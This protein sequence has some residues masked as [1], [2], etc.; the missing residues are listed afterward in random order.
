VNGSQW[1]AFVTCFVDSGRPSAADDICSIELPLPY[2]GINTLQF[3]VFEEGAFAAAHPLHTLV[4]WL[5]LQG[6]YGVA[7]STAPRR[8]C[9]MK[10]AAAYLW[11]D[12]PYPM[13][14]A[15]RR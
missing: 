5:C 7:M 3:A 11:S 10:L 6:V 14:R 12:S 8:Q 4:T 13:H 2:A 1:G 15:S 9:A